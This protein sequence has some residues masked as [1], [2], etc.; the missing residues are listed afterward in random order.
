MTSSYRYAEP[1]DEPFILSGWSA[2]YRQS[3][4]IAFVQ[5]SAYA[6]VMHPIVLSVLARPRVQT[7]VAHGEMRRGFICYEHSQT[8]RPPLVN[9]VYVAQPYRRQGHARGLFMAAGIDPDGPFEYA[10]RTRMSWEL[11][12][13]HGKTPMA[14]YN[15]FRA[16]YAEEET[17][18]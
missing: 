4:D 15:P 9:Y 8:G 10:A 3:R 16:R 17:A 11:H 7:I 18:A 2:S 13:R 12:E 14:R 1:A 5:M 6:D